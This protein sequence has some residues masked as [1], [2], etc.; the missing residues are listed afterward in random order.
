MRMLVLMLVVLFVSMPL[1]GCGSK[2]KEQANSG[3]LLRTYKLVDEQGRESG[4]LVINPLGGAELRD[5]DG[6][7][8]G[9][10]AP[11]GAPEAAPKAEEKA[12]NA[13]TEKE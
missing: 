8:M 2:A 12:D 6:T 9:T 7:V 3:S 13:E 1:A 10:F 11:G 4:T 5:I